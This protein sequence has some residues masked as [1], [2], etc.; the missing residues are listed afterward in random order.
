MYKLC[1]HYFEND[2]KVSVTSVEYSVE[3]PISWYISFC[4]INSLCFLPYSFTLLRV[5][6][7]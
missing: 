6:E 2:R 3:V 5:F 7:W 4:T 1:G